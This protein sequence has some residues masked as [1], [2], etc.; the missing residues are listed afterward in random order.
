MIYI[1]D[2]D[3]YVRRGFSFLLRS[4]KFDCTAFGSAEE[5]IDSYKPREDDV[6]ILDIHMPGMDGCGLLEYLISANYKPHVII[7][8]AYDEISS[9]NCAK[10]YGALAF[11]RKPIDGDALIDL[12]K[13]AVHMV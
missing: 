7:I 11:L 10:K 2:D 1:V 13:Y 6:L 12:I 5:F 3:L 9:R 8:S 4:A